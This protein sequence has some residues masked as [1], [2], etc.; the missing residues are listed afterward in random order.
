MG[1]S[2][3][4]GIG[5]FVKFSLPVLVISVC[6][7]AK[8]AWKRTGLKVY[9]GRKMKKSIAAIILL[10]ALIGC[11]SNES[12]MTIQD[13]QRIS[14]EQ[15]SNGNRAVRGKGTI[16]AR[17]SQNLMARRTSDGTIADE[18]DY[19]VD[20]TLGLKFTPLSDMSVVDEYGTHNGLIVVFADDAGH[21]IGI[22]DAAAAYPGIT[23][24]DINRNLSEMKDRG[25]GFYEKVIAGTRDAAPMVQ[26]LRCVGSDEKIYVV[27][28]Y[29]PKKTYAKVARQFRIAMKSL[30]F[31]E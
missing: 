4:R 28:A 12:S 6:L 9:G 8:S 2:S 22:L 3:K 14:W 16:P 31:D 18:P 10:S 26:L 5:T 30:S 21:T 27:Q 19:W 17:D 25:D 15:G 23:W 29:A 20:K 1:T 11:Q 24:S 7:D 13:E